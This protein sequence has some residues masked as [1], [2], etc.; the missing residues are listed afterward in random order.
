MTNSRISR[1]VTGFTLIEL[2]VVIA[3]IAIL[4]AML[5]PALASA[6]E[7]AKRIQCLNNLKQVGLGAFIYA[8]DNHEKLISAR[9]SGGSWVQLAINPPEQSQWKSLGL[10]IQTNGSSIWTCPNRKSYPFY[11]AQYNQFSIGYQY[12]GG[13]EEWKNAMGTFTGASPVKLA[14]SKPAWALA[15]DVV[16]K[17][18]GKW[19]PTDPRYADLPP[20]KG[21]GGL[22]AGGN[23]VYCDGSANWEKFNTMYAFHSWVPSTRV[24][25][26][27]QDPGSVDRILQTRLSQLAAKP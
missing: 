9:T 3:I 22:P 11:E 4:A 8:G 21:S 19:S 15:A 2:L 25:Y 12:F 27:Y 10:D 23:Q 5:L 18:D 16:A 13:I 6:K 14:N 17:I 24:C 1:R 7:R 20:H 26:W